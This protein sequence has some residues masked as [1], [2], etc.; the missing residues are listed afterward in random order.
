M[1]GMNFLGVGPA[2]IP[3]HTLTAEPLA[4]AIREAVS[5]TAM[6]KWA[7]GIGQRLQEEDGVG[8]A[9]EI[10]SQYVTRFRH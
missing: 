1:S 10:F 8:R 7:A 3:S 6:H 4:D 2:P 9:I 5:N